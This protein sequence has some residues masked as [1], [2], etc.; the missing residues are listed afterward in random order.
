MKEKLKTLK[1]LNIEENPDWE[2]SNCGMLNSSDNQFCRDCDRENYE[3]EELKKEI[4]EEIKEELK[5]LKDLKA[6]VPVSQIEDVDSFLLKAEAV[7]WVKSFTP[8]KRMIEIRSIFMEFFNIT[9]EDLQ[10]EK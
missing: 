5:T 1:D 2:C 8:E 3:R 7:K 6:D 4:K 10:E 9:E